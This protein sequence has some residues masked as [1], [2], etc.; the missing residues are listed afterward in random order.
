MLVLT[1]KY[2]EKIRIGEN[3]T[4]TVLRMK[5]KAVRLGI[6]APSTVP[7][8]RGELTFATQGDMAE[9]EEVESATL[10]FELAEESS[11]SSGRTIARQTGMATM[12]STESRPDV[13]DRGVSH[14]ANLKVGFARVS[15]E[16]VAD[17]LPK[18]A[19]SASP[20][21]AMLNKRS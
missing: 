1:R 12:W 9:A 18:L 21:R 13:A 16:K 14:A 17:L 6:E 15:R 20:L 3:I 5:G 7:V 4:I 11:T 2:Q 19:D 8:V 10:E